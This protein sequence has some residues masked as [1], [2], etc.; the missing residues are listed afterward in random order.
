MLS[1]WVLCVLIQTSDEP[2]HPSAD[3]TETQ[4][5]AEAKAKAGRNADAQ[6]RLALW[7]EAHGMMAE[8]L[9]H[10][11]IALLVDPSHPLARGLLG[12]VNDAGA[13][14]KSDDAA[15]RMANDAALAKARADYE[16]KRSEVPNQAEA[17]YRLALW[18][19]QN[20]LKAEA[21]AHLHHTIGLDPKREEAWKRLGYKRYG[22]RWMTNAQIATAKRESEERAAADRKWKPILER[23]KTDLGGKLRRADAEHTLAEITDPQAVPMIIHVFGTGK[24]ADQLRAVR[25]LG[26]I[27]DRAASRSLATLSVFGKS[28][29]VRRIAT[30]TLRQ[31]DPREFADFLISLLRDPVKYQVKPVG[32]PGSPGE[33]WVEGERYDRKR[34]Y[35]APVL[36]SSA[37]SLYPSDR[38]GYDQEGLPVVVRSLGML[39]VSNPVS[40]NQFPVN[41]ATS[42]L[43]LYVAP[44]F[45]STEIRLVPLPPVLP[46]ILNSAMH[47]GVGAHSPATPPGRSA[48]APALSGTYTSAQ[49]MF[50]N[51]L[52]IPIGQV[53]RAQ[54]IA[55]MSAQSQLER[56]VAAIESYN[57][58]IQT[59]NARVLPVLES[60]TGNRFGESRKAWD[61][62]LADLAGTG[63][64]QPQ[65][66]ARQ[67]VEDAVMPEIVPQAAPVLSQA[68]IGLKLNRM[69]CFARGTSIQTMSGPRPIESVALGDLVLSQHAE[70]GALSFQP[71]VRVYH[72]PPHGTLR[73]ELDNDVIVC[74]SIHRIWV[75]GRGWV[76]ARDLKPD[77]PLRTTTGLAKVVAVR[78]DAEQLVFNLRVAET[79][80]FFVGKARVLAHDN[81]ECAARLAPF[82]A[83]T[84]LPDSASPVSTLEPNPGSR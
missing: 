57:A 37:L 48:P 29:D 38:L 59:L 28:D 84:K 51:E 5:Y 68:V 58:P 72:N 66:S 35:L 74:T 3:A 11:A 22:N 65:M 24:A 19:E 4:V 83:L 45:A 62:W 36:L 1:A 81:S 47:G 46:P 15:R 39:S 76:M 9:K 18:C 67:T 23:A 26:Q 16:R 42:G 8:R 80:S 27:N 54:R 12:F 82:D 33:L 21:K 70:T 52:V 14:R 71:V 43:P 50:S 44:S 55:A 61:E 53:E 63:W 17:H 34:K 13:W 31:R 25:L 49:D 77:D 69:S 7:C 10:L 2:K 73:V 20:G 60:V 79:H 30:E 56:E 78:D 6:V 64:T 32:G 40:F 75:A 41:P